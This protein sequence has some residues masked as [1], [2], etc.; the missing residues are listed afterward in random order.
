V[1]RL[2]STVPR[3]YGWPGKSAARRVECGRTHLGV[4]LYCLLSV[5][6]TSQ[7][8]A[9]SRLNTDVVNM[10]NGDRITCEI[11]SLGHEQL[12]V[13]QPYASSTVALDWN[14]VD[15]IQAK[16]PFVVIDTKACS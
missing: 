8:H 9:S 6:F 2:D 12:T 5:A 14:E 13:K 7:M 11:R 4:L 16:Q 3:S 10:K 1:K 15:N